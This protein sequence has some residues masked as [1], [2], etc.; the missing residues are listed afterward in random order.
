MNFLD[1][2]RYAQGLREAPYVALDCSSAADLRWL[3]G[4]T[5][6]NCARASARQTYTKCAKVVRM[7]QMLI[8]T[9]KQKK[10]KTAPE[11]SNY[12][13]LLDVNIFC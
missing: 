4:S 12:V 10:K 5:K 6:C 9:R 3:S 13:N 1:G 2:F 11:E 7:S 8:C